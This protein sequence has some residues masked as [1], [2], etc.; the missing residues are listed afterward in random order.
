MRKLKVVVS[1]IAGLGMAL[2]LAG[3]DAKESTS[4]QQERQRAQISSKANHAVPVPDVN[5]FVT[6]QVV[7]EY[8]KRMDQPNKLFYIYVLADT[9][10]AIGYFV[11]KGPPVNIC[12]NMTPPDKIDESGIH[13]DVVRTAPSLNGLYN[14]GNGVCNKD[15]FFDA[16]SNALLS[17]K[18]LKAFISDQ[19]LNLNVE[20]ITVEEKPG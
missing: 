11:S 5:N 16:N 19:P 8:M 13:S 6:R 10:N 15:Y 9:G 2:A 12:N 4:Q 20:P 14:A 7:A 1:A 17:L 18:D 3:C